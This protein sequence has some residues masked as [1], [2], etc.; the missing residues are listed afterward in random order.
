MQD[1]PKSSVITVDTEFSGQRLDNF[2]LR[3]LKGA[4]RSLVYRIVR[5]G[6]VRVNKSRARANLRLRAGDEVRIPPLKLSSKK[7]ART[8]PVFK[9]ISVP[10][11]FEDEH[12]LVVDKPAHIAVHGGSGI[13]AGLIEHIRATRPQLRY[14]ELVHRLDRETSGCLMLAKRRSVLRTLHEDLRQNSRVRHRFKKKYQALVTGQ[15]PPARRWVDTPLRKNTLLSGERV[16]VPDK[17]GL[18][19]KTGFKAVRHFNDCTLVEAT[20]ITGRTHQA[21][22]H[23]ASS[24]HPILGDEKYG[25]KQANRAFRLLGL[26][27]LFLHA[28]YLS[29]IHPHTDQK[30]ELTSPLP[31]DLAGILSKCETDEVVAV[32]GA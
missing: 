9:D 32:Q 31:A 25:D 4:P 18:Y 30:I 13:R 11:L 28:S 16:V 23:A 14:I 26:H 5:R 12:V 10:V 19:T 6:E 2:L 29:F 8:A 7:G 24:G 3:E 22:V 27:R 1:K 21:R 15:W 20:L 17:D